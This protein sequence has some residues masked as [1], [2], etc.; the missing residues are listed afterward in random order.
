LLGQCD[1]LI[2]VSQFVARVLREGFY[3]P[4]SPE[5]ERR[6]RPPLRGDHSRIHVIAPGIDTHRFYPAQGDGLRREWGIASSHFVFAVVGGY[7][8]PRGKGQR[9]FLR[10]AAQVHE[11]IP[12]ARFLIIGRGNLRQTLEEDIRRFGLQDKAALTPYCH[13]MPA[14]MNSLDC[15][16][17]PQVGTEAFGA[18]L[19][20]AFACGRPVIASALDGIPEAFAVGGEGRLV[21]PEDVDGLAAA[22]AQQAQNTA[23]T[24]PQR[25]ALHERIAKHFSL[26]CLANKVL[27]FYRQLLRSCRTAR[28]P[29]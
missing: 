27:A 24:F 15:L 3:E 8:L 13:D 20:E 5:P 9:E 14:A 19:L 26:E 23:L 25:Q 7:D 28:R 11:R 1:G 4:G 22:L 2:A 17:H 10:A 29:D 6:A 12:H 18:V 16:V 21:A